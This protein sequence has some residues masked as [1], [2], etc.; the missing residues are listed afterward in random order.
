MRKLAS[1]QKIEKVE[2]HPNA[3]RLELATVLGWQCVVKKGDFKAGD[4]CVYFEIDSVLPDR[5]EFEFMRERKFRVRTIKL[6]GQLSQGLA[7]KP[8]EAGIKYPE[9]LSPG[10]DVSVLLGVTKYDPEAARERGYVA[11][12]AKNRK[13]LKPFPQYI[14]KTDEPRL[15]NFPGVLE[16]LK[17]TP[18]Y[19][20][21]K[22][23]G[24]SA[25]YFRDMDGSLVIA[26]RN[27]TLDPLPD[28]TSFRYKAL[29]KGL[30][31]LA[32]VTS[33]VC[34]LGFDR[35]LS[36]L[37]RIQRK[38]TRLRD[39]DTDTHYHEIARKYSLDRRIPLGYAFQGEITG[40]KIFGQKSGVENGFTELD[41][42]VFG[43]YSVP[44]QTYL[45]LDAAENMVYD[46]GCKFVPVD[47]IWI[48]PE[49][50]ETIKPGFFTL[51]SFLELAKG[52]YGNGAPREGIVVRAIKPTKSKVL[53]GNLSF[54]VINNDYLLSVK[55]EEEEAA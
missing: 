9:R 16:E 21:E 22:L 39:G 19:I 4:L 38:I 12:T 55:D 29:S 25:T 47:A 2:P 45:D 28:K 24:C 18:F 34:G 13:R 26:S 1:I 51:K 20:T 52:T 17:T 10:D 14:P 35:P 27:C 31:A 53:G 44:E 3:D 42:H 41:F 6:R 33:I 37:G 40:P 32:W 30:R 23:D 48:H 8:E 54:K 46:A 7:L 36:F 50:A 5:P 11:R 43:V 15:Q 49:A